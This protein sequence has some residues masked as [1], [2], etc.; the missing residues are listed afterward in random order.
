MFQHLQSADTLWIAGKHYKLT[1]VTNKIA[2]IDKQFS[3]ITINGPNYNEQILCLE[4]WWLKEAKKYLK[5]TIGERLEQHKHY[6]YPTPKIK[7]SFMHKTLAKYSLKTN[8]IS[9]NMTL[10][11]ARISDIFLC[12]DIALDGDVTTDATKFDITYYHKSWS[13]KFCQFQRWLH[14]ESVLFDFTNK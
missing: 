13:H 5:Q 6:F 14:N 3:Q 4:E 8:T 7:L 12:V 9:I 1:Y 10:G 2:S 11:Q